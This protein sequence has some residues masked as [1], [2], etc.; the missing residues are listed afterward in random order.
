MAPLRLRSGQALALLLAFGS[1]KT[2][3]RDLHPDSYGPCPAHTKAS[4]AR[5]EKALNIL[6]THKLN[7]AQ[8]SEITPQLSR[9][10]DALL[11]AAV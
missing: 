8:N 1:A 3:R 4:P 9:Q 11:A 7:S 6:E 2:L 5:N 10:V